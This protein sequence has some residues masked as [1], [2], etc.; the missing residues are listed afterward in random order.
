MLREELM[1]LR[2]QRDAHGI[3]SRINRVQMA[4]LIYSNLCEQYRC[5]ASVGPAL[6]K[7]KPA[8]RDEQANGC[9]EQQSRERLAF[10][11]VV[12]EGCGVP[13]GL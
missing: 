9:F 4:M 11:C 10:L 6:S 13:V 2:P 12:G 7:G 8:H 1:Q 5:F 3:S